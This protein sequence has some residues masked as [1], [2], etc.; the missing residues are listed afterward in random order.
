[1]AEL[2]TTTNHKISE[3]ND[4]M[5]HLQPKKETFNQADHEKTMLGVCLRVWQARYRPLALVMVLGKQATCG[6]QREPRRQGQRVC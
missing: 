1:M 4:E 6:V 2:P 3:A 5:K